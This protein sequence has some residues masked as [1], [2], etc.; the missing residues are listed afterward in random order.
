M[1]TTSTPLLLSYCLTCAL[2]AGQRIPTAAA[3]RQAPTPT[4]SLSRQAQLAQGP[5]LSTQPSGQD[6]RPGKP[7]PVATLLSPISDEDD[8]FSQCV[9]KVGDVNAD[10]Y[11]DVVV[12]AYGTNQHRGQAYLYLG[13]RLGLAPTPS[14]TLPNPGTS[15]DY[16][17]ASVAGVGDVNGDGYAD[18]LIGAY[19]TGQQQGK[20]YL[21]LGSQLGLAQAPSVGLSDPGAKKYGSFGSSLAGVGDVNGDGYADALVGSGCVY[22][23]QQGQFGQAYL[24]LGG[25]A[26]L[27]A[28]P[29]TTFIDPG[30]QAGNSFGQSVAG[31]GDVNKD[32]YA[33]LL[34]G[35]PNTTASQ[36]RAYL[37]L[38]RRQGPAAVP[39]QLLETPAPTST[40]LFGFSVAG[41]GDVDHDGYADVLVGAYGTGHQPGQAY[42]YRGGAT[43]LSPKPVATLKSPDSRAG[44]LFGACVTGI[45]D[46]NQDGYADVAV[47]G[48][49]P[50]GSAGA[51]YLYFGSSLGLS[52]FPNYTLRPPTSTALTFFSNSISGVGDVNGDGTADLLIGAYDINM[53][54]G[55]AHLYL[56]EPKNTPPTTQLRQQAASTGLAP[57]RAVEWGLTAYPNPYQGGLQAQLTTPEAGT[58]SLLLLDATGRQLVQQQQAVVAGSQLLQLNLSQPLP[59]GVY[60]LLVRQNTHSG[61]VRLL[62][63]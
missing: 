41:A 20:A 59:A 28:M 51:A 55:A 29:H 26:G 40:N 56:G 44:D 61:T 58:V 45:G 34:I 23:G 39:A 62:H 48:N 52:T 18:V 6:G 21:Y 32:G 15:A 46:F 49:S 12:G 53:G 31:A 50:T 13:S 8:L 60:L 24:Y 16:F 17:G 63:N 30:K 1:A 14:C 35:A 43:G 27:A 25:R 10:G 4:F 33:D 47:G 38:G 54:Q 2:L 5:V 11:A 19:G 37:Y 57:T 9:A 42:V 36:G 3:Q 7:A 22:E